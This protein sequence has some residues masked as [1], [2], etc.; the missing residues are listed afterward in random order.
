MS[1]KMPVW[2]RSARPRDYFVGVL[3]EKAFSVTTMHCFVSIM[4]SVCLLKGEDVI[5]SETYFMMELPFTKI[6]A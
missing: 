6:H 3:T 5:V 1:E 2:N 4:L